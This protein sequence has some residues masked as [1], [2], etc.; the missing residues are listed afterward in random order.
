MRGRRFRG[1]GGREEVDVRCRNRR[2]GARAEEEVG[3][4][5]GGETERKEQGG[6]IGGVSG[7]RFGL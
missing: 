5:G 1:L 7:L 4:R 6:E 2:Y 3:R